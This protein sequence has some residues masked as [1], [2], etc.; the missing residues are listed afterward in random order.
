MA[1]G[2]PDTSAWSPARVRALQQ[3]QAAQII[4]AHPVLVSKVMLYGATK[5]LV[6]TG[7]A[8]LLHFFGGVP[9]EARPAGA[10]AFSL[11]ATRERLTRSPWAVALVAYVLLHLA[12]VY[13]GAARGVL[14]V[15]RGARS[16]W[17]AHVLL[18]GIAI[19]LVVVAAGPEAYARFRVPVMPFLAIFAG[20]GWGSSTR[21]VT[22]GPG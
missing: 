6:G 16:R 7:H 4:A 9:Y 1:A 22:P 21:R 13:A 14:R 18:A 19:Y 3:R 2:L 8:D 10:S 15:T 11:E 20:I 17:P 12:R 5:I